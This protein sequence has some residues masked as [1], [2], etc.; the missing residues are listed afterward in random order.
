MRRRVG[1]AVLCDV[2]CVES[3]QVARRQRRG[4]KRDHCVLVAASRALRRPDFAALVRE[5]DGFMAWLDRHR[6][7]GVRG[8][9][10]VEGGGVPLPCALLR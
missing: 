1:T 3:S 2:H 5:A 7:Y 9:T 4:Q 6:D 10:H 8:G